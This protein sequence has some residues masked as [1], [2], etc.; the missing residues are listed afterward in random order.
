MARRDDLHAVHPAAVELAARARQPGRRRPRLRRSR[1]CRRTPA[2][3]FTRRTCGSRPASR[4]APASRTMNALDTHDTPRFRTHARAG[5]GAG[6]VRARGDAAGHPGGLGRR[7]VRAHRRRRRGLAHADPVGERGLGRVA[8]VLDDRTARSSRC[9]AR[10]RC[11]P[12]G[13][14]RWLAVGDDAVAFVR[15]SADERCSCSR[16]G[17][18]RRSSFDAA[19]GGA[20]RR[21]GCRGAAVRG[22]RGSR[23]PMVW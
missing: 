3:E 1:R 16:R 2:R 18:R 14:I 17:R 7:R 22:G 4:G 20:C 13:G 11:S 6:G 19:L 10:T 21:S 15:E 8:P 5:R 9:G 23:H 12:T